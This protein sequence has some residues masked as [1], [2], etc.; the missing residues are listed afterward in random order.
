MLNY[1][2]VTFIVPGNNKEI[3]FDILSVLPNKANIVILDIGK[4][5]TL[6]SNIISRV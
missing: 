5:S 6:D 4:N 2:E 3:I 1:E